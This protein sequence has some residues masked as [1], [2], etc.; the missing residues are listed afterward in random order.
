MEED[1]S[2]ASK[3]VRMYRGTA[4][5]I[6][7][8]MQ[9]PRSEPPPPLPERAAP[10]PQTLHPAGS[11]DCCIRQ[12]GTRSEGAHWLFHLQGPPPS[13]PGLRVGSGGGEWV[14]TCSTFLF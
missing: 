4:E 3:F 1:I 7:P 12:V 11:C 14:R 5:S 2:W 10:R 13:L 6:H 9:C 8:S